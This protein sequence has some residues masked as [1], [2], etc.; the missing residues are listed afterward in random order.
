MKELLRKW[1][2]TQEVLELLDVIPE[3]LHLRVVDMYKVWEFVA[4]AQYVQNQNE[5]V[6]FLVYIPEDYDESVSF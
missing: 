5:E 3:R 2:I 6:K 4:D 1:I